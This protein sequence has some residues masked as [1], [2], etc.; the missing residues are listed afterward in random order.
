CTAVNCLAGDGGMHRPQIP[1]WGRLIQGLRQAPKGRTGSASVGGQPPGIS[2][3]SLVQGNTAKE[4]PLKAST[5][6]KAEV[7]KIVFIAFVLPP[8]WGPMAGIKKKPWRKGNNQGLFGRW[9]VSRRGLRRRRTRI[10]P[11]AEH[12][13]SGASALVSRLS[14]IPSNKMSRIVL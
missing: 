11:L 10:K 3:R 8:R 5:K 9:R 13:S 12:D 1:A 4:G 14:S 2:Q 7:A 6:G